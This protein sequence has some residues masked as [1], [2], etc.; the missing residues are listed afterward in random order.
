M[1]TKLKAFTLNEMVIVMIISTIVI[2]L[3][4]TV[5]S[6]VQRHMS[7]IQKNFSLKTEFNHLEQALW[8]DFNKYNSIRFNEKENEIKLKNEIDSTLYRITPDFVLKD[9]D[10]LNIKIDQTLFFFNGIE[11]SRGKVDAVKITLSEQFKD[12]KI[13]V[14]KRNDAFQFIN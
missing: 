14:F 2:G 12:Q 10:T 13:F 4:F 11:V 1:K 8:V 5:L 7:S 9:E 3:A 6:M